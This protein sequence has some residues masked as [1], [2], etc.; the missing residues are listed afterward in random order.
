M[1]TRVKTTKF[2]ATIIRNAEKLLSQ[3]CIEDK[4]QNRGDCIRNLQ[5]RFNPNRS[6][7]EAYCAKTT[8]VF[9][10]DAIDEFGFDGGNVFETAGARL[11]RDKAKKYVPVNKIPVAGSVFYISPS[12]GSSGSG[13][14]GLVWSVSE[15]GKTFKTIEGNAVGNAY[16]GRNWTAKKEG[17]I[18]RTRNI[19]SV[20]AFVHVEQYKETA[21]V[22]YALLSGNTN[23]GGLMIAGGWLFGITVVAI[24]G[25]M[26]YEKL[27]G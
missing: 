8:S 13:H 27:K 23:G 12:S 26:L 16:D 3:Y 20:N 10:G 7:T 24:G 17:V 14:V 18:S 21:E 5:K 19:S 9:V 6:L 1:G 2:G 11:F 4:G 15:D 25:G 22:N